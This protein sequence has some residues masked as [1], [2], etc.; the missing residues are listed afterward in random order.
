MLE[1]LW[2]F[3]FF[4][5][6]VWHNVEGNK[7][8]FGHMEESKRHIFALPILCLSLDSTAQCQEALLVQSLRQP[9]EVS[10]LYHHIYFQLE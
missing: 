5:T 9:Y 4:E 10:V 3:R 7:D 1:Q 2:K 8:E 6:S